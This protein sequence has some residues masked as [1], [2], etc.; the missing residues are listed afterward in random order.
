MTRRARQVLDE[1]LKLSPEE[2]SLVLRELLARLEGEPDPDAEA[3][4]AQEIERRA[5]DARAGTPAAG[6]WETV[7]D[8]I[9]AELPG[10]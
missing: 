4:W 1:A 2:Q 10:K 7:C 6:D 3:A 8:E 5:Q 9:E